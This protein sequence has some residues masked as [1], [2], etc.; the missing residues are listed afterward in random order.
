[1]LRFI[2]LV[3]QRDMW[4]IKVYSVIPVYHQH[5]IPDNSLTRPPE[6][7]TKKVAKHSSISCMLMQDWSYPSYSRSRSL[8]F[9]VVDATLSTYSI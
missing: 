3:L 2:L 7:L 5:A 9:Q 4:S 1:M 6:Q 8:Y